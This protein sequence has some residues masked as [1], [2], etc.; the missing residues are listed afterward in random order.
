M[1]NYYKEQ[2]EKI[3]SKLSQVEHE[4]R[5]Y[6]KIVWMISGGTSA[7]AVLVFWCIVMSVAIFLFVRWN[8]L[9]VS[10][11]V[12]VIGLV[13]GFISVAIKYRKIILNWQEELYL[14]ELRREKEINELKK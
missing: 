11:R 6:K 12:A 8:V 14:Y 9:S 10:D 5:F 3:K 13:G 1:E 4:A 2:Y 7:I